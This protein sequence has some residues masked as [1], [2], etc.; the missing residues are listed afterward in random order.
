MLLKGLAI[1][2]TWVVYKNVS[3]SEISFTLSIVHVF[4]PFGSYGSLNSFTISDTNTVD[5]SGHR[6]RNK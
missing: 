3:S 5:R 1:D 2:F 6:D 4:D